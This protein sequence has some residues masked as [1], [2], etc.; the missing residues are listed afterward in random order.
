MSR[1]FIRAS[2]IRSTFILALSLASLVGTL[3]ISGVAAVAVATG[4]R[5]PVF[6][7]AAEEPTQDVTQSKVWYHDGKWWA[8]MFDDTT[9]AN[10]IYRLD[11]TAWTKTEAELDDRNDSHADYLWDGTNLHVASVNGDSA[12]DAIEYYKYGYD[13]A[14]DTW[15]LVSGPIQVGV[16]PSESVTIARSGSNLWITFTNPGATDERKVMVNNS[17]DNGATWSSTTGSQLV[18]G[19][20]PVVTDDEA[21]SAIVAFGA[22]VGVMWSDQRADDVDTSTEF[23]FSVNSAPSSGSFNSPVVAASGDEG[24]AEDH[25]NLKVDSAGRVLA[26]V[27]T[28]GG[29]HVHLLVRATTGDWTEHVVVDS[30]VEATRPQVVV[31]SSTDEAWVF[32]TIPVLHSD[33]DQQIYYKKAPLGTLAFSSGNGTLFIDDAPNDVNNISLSKHSVT[34]TTGVL[35]LASSDEN[36]SVNA[37]YHN[38]LGGIAPTPS[39][40]PTPS[41]S[42]SPTPSPD[43]ANPFTDVTTANSFYHDILWIYREGITA[44]CASDR[45]CPKAD[46]TRAQMASF[47]VR[48]LDLRRTTSIDYFDDDETSIHEADINTLADS[49]ITFGCAADRF[50]P[51]SPVRRDQMA[52]FLVRGFDIVPDP[53]RTDRFG[54]DNGNTHEADINA[55]AASGITGGCGP[56]RYCPTNVVNREQMAAF[57]HRALT[58]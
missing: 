9:D 28:N 35:G 54:D 26:A 33:G 41:P 51:N 31:N 25:I 6:G 16:G 36:S 48:A 46:V 17:T 43:P 24:F 15:A 3:F 50:C 38:L 39:P 45:Y 11:G 21:A 57:L 10:F 27:K 47:L 20:T 18:A 19:T 53:S 23:L 13:T 52:S 37:Y 7:E 12:A 4:H 1:S 34:S 32:Y 49:K 29:P 2:S 58:R 22:S 14:S 30:S 8:G 5:G 56:D 55:L 42:P 40:T 44:G